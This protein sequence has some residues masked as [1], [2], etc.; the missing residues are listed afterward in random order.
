[1]SKP[2]L[3]ARER[4]RYSRQLLLPSFGFDGQER[5][6]AATAVIIG[7]G[8]LGCAAAPY[9]VSAGIGRL[10]LID[11][12]SVETHNLPRQL[13]YRD[14]DVGQPKAL[15]AAAVL[16]ALNPDASIEGIVGQLDDAALRA[17]VAQADVVLD[18]SDNLATREQ[19]NRL[20]HDTRTPLIS[21]AAIR[22]E[23]QVAVFPMTPGAPCYQCLSHRFGER[24]LSCLE[25]GV[26]APL[27]GVIGSLQALEAIKMVTGRAVATAERTPTPDAEI[28]GKL[29][30]FD[31]ALGQWQSLRLEPWPDCPVCGA[32]EN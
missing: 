26:L 15:V 19:I 12:D 31:G 25:A 29:L 20:C 2:S 28:T 13:L 17:Q 24:Q 22:L 18:C 8:G 6:R 7:A 3:S 11:F 16:T 4:Q 10:V 23:G 21:G 5:L 30:L 9:L 32:T 1:M 14:A 27:V